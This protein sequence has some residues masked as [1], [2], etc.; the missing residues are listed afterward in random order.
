MDIQTLGQVLILL[1]IIGASS[2][3][4]YKNYQIEKKHG[5]LETQKNK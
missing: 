2:Y 4:F 1:F 3:G 5:W